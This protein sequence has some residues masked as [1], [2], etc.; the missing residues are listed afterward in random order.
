[1]HGVL[2]LDKPSGCTSHDLTLRARQLLGE[3]RLGH[4]GT[5]DPL[6]TGVLPLL[7]GEAARLAEY[8]PTGK[9]YEAACRLD[10]FTDTD[11]VTGAPLPTPSVSFPD[12]ERVRLAVEGLRMV[13]EQI[14]PMVSAV[15]VDGI[16]LYE[17]ARKGI[18]IERKARPVVIGSVECLSVEG[19]RVRFRVACSGGTYVRSL[20]R[21]LGEGLGTG[22]CLESLRRLEAGP[23]T[24]GEA[25]SWETFEKSVRE[26]A[27]VLQPSLRLVAHLP[28]VKLDDR[29]AEDVLHGRAPDAPTGTPEG[30]VCLVNPQGKVAAIAEVNGGKLRPKKVFGKEGI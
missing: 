17:L 13:T 3:S 25:L 7:V 23:F 21:T 9:V 6:A 4:L 22:G 28:L 15:K 16:R 29:M 26:S 12:P 5:L 11:D 8:A 1:M 10:L 2:V 24:I 18:T 30:L 20:C 19:M 14:P 27:V